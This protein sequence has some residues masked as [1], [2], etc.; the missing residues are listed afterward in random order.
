MSLPKT[1]TRRHRWVTLDR[2][3]LE[4]AEITADQLASE[5]AVVLGKLKDTG[6]EEIAKAVDTTRY[7]LA[8]SHIGKAMEKYAK[9]DAVDD[10]PLVVTQLDASHWY[11]Q[12]SGH[13][14]ARV[15]QRVKELKHRYPIRSHNALKLQAIRE[16]ILNERKRM[17]FEKR[18]RTP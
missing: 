8:G 5:I 11:A 17:N 6:L 18:M 13:V 14:T 4:L 3:K 10:N 16:A 2:E 9:N 1:K 12:Q 7:S 15:E